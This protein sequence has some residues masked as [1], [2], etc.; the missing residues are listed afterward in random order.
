MNSGPSEAYLRALGEAQR[1]HARSKTYSGRFL[2]PHKPFLSDLIKRLGIESAIDYGCGKGGQYEWVDPDD[3]KTLEQAWG[4]AV[5]KFDPAW[6]PYAAEPQ[7]QFDLVIC[8]HVLGGIPLAD[9][10]WVIPRLFEMG[11]KAVFIAEKIGPIH[12][13]VHADRAGMVD[14]W[15]RE[16]WA[17][18]LRGFMGAGCG[19]TEIHLSTLERVGDEKITTRQVL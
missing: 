11:T 7:G 10:Q 13:K 3:G 6:P 4:F 8:T 16:R 18:H 5:A 12:K 14:G 15:T 2:R 17:S 1:H 9:H 19:R